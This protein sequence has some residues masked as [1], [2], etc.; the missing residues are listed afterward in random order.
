MFTQPMIETR[1]AQPYVALHHKTD[2]GSLITLIPHDVDTLTEWLGSRGVVPAGPPLVRYHMC[3]TDPTPDAPLEISIGFPTAELMLSEEP[4]VVGTLPEGNYATLVFTGVENGIAG[5]AALIEWAQQHGHRWDSQ[6]VEGGEQ[7]SGR[8]ESMIDG[9][10]DNP[11]TAEW[12]TEVAI[13]I[14]QPA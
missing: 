12:R 5:N 9:P 4:F 7:F 6:P 3:P 13:R 10:E 1:P 11:D 14:A 8:Y 2:I